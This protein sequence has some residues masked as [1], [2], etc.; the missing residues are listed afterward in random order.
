R[1]ADTDEIGVLSASLATAASELQATEQRRR[2]FLAN[3]AHEIRTPVTSI[4]G[5]ADILA[6]GGADDAT[7][8]EFVQT[9][10]RNSVRIGQLVEDLLELEALDAG[11]GP[12]LADD[13]VGLA[14]IASHVENT[15]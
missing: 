12:K 9:I 1:K 3:V 13:A 4:R 14:A 11:K 8:R 2:D 10:Q 15:L 7:S 6:R 5:Y